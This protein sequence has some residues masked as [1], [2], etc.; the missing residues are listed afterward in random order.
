[1]A[2]GLRHQFGGMHANAGTPPILI[3]KLMQHK[4]LRTTQRYIEITE[5]TLRSGAELTDQLVDEYLNDNPKDLET[6]SN[7]KRA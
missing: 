5:P 4:E 7:R 3:Q 1:M 6:T 2:H